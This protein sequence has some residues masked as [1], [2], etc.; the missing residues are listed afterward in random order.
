VTY[1]RTLLVAIVLLLAS[2][3]G[4]AMLAENRQGANVYV[5]PNEVVNNNLYAVGGIVD[6]EGTVRGNVVAVGASV[7]VPAVVTGDLNA[8][9]GVLTIPGRV[10]GEVRTASVT[11]TINGT[12]G[13]DVTISGGT[14][15]IGPRSRIAQDVLVIGQSATIAGVI[16][17]NLRVYANDLTIGGAIG[18]NVR[19]VVGTLRLTPGAVVAGNLSYTS[20]QEAMIAPGAI[21]RG[22]VE[23]HQLPSLPGLNELGQGAVTS[24]IAI[25]WPSTEVG[26]FLMGLAY[27]LLFPTFA[28]LTI[29]AIWRRPWKSL[30]LGVV[31]LIDGPL[32]AILLFIVGLSIGG[33]WLG[34]ILLGLY[35]IALILAY[36]STALFIGNVLFSLAGRSSPHLAVVLLSGLIVLTLFCQLPIVGGVIRFVALVMGLGALGIAAIQERRA[37]RRTFD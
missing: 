21:V 29:G 11:A 15:S 31:L 16:G 17:Q 34:F 22:S 33:W 6:I 3:S 32:L 13:K 20:A 23:R 19:A 4:L 7:V 8:T 27:V 37:P 36:I 9:G 30:A 12:V 5:G 14:L 35:G 24:Q 26:V 1:R 28:H 25:S 2:V 18:G 10:D